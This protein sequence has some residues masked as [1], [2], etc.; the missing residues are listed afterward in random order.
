MDYQTLS[1]SACA[2]EVLQVILNCTGNDPILR[3]K[4]ERLVRQK[5]R[6]IYEQCAMI[7]EDYTTMNDP[8]EKLSGLAVG[9]RIAEEIRRCAEER[10]NQTR[11]L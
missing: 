10:R 11:L 3:D 2:A 7:A 6:L 8:L 5:V 4:V 9:D 1:P